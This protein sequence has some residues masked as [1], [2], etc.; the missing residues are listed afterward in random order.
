MIALFIRCIFILFVVSAFPSFIF[1]PMENPLANQER[2]SMAR[3][4]TNQIQLKQTR[5]LNDLLQHFLKGYRYE[6]S[7]GSQGILVES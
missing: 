3:D 5:S 2:E 7:A 4:M 6:P 1:D